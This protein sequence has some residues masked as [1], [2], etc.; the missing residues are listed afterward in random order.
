[1]MY[2][3]ECGKLKRSR[4]EARGCDDCEA[5]D[6]QRLAR[7]GGVSHAVKSLL[8]R[9]YPDWLDGSEIRALV[10]NKESSA[11]L[12]RLVKAGAVERRQFAGS[13]MEYR[14]RRSQAA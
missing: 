10:N 13:G 5:L 8:V 3:C 7:T 2:E 11:V 1:M 6:R 4:S 9:H 12:W 14:L